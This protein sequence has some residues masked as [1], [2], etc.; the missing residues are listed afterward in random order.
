MLR[1][2]G[3]LIT[4]PGTKHQIKMKIN[5]I[6]AVAEHN[7][8]GAN[9]Q[10]IWHLPADL[11]YFKALTMGHTLIMGRKTFD[12]IGKPLKGRSTIVVT[13]NKHFS[14]PGCMVASSL[15]SAMRMAD[16]DREVFI[17]GGEQIYRRAIL[18]M[19]VTRI[20]LT[21]IYASFDG[22]AF[23]PEIDP[24]TWKLNNQSDHLPD[25]KNPYPYSF[26]V[27]QRIIQ[28]DKQ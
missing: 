1:I 27:Y 11:K 15:E 13:R 18:L 14:A 19:Q 23:F 22:D 10:L 17:A 12:S 8:I 4:E 26:Q 3:L 6:A 21:R 16:H 24:A 5:M 25:E 9:N 28:D 20:Y 7:V 2:S